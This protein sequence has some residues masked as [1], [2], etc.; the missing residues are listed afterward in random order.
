MG[1]IRQE[2]P[3]VIFKMLERKWIEELYQKGTMR[4]YAPGKWVQYEIDGNRGQGDKYEGVFA[5]DKNGQN[6]EAE[7]RE[8]Y[9]E[10][11][12]VNYDGINKYYQLQET[13]SSPTYCFYSLGDQH[14]EVPKD[15]ETEGQYEIKTV[16]AAD[17]F[18]DFARGMS[19]EEIEKLPK[20]EQPALL[21][22]FGYEN[23]KTFFKKVRQAL[24]HQHGIKDSEVL[25]EQVKYCY[26]RQDRDSYV[27]PRTDPPKEL[28][29]KG[30]EFENQREAR[31]VLD[32]GRHKI[33]DYENDFVEIEIGSMQ[34]YAFIHD[35]YTPNGIAISAEAVF[36]EK[37]NILKRDGYIHKGYE[38]L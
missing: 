37:Q 31:I 35:G 27:S 36:S 30:R 16:I 18:Q 15:I 14:F 20:E 29:E 38:G 5:I 23:I 21:I 33:S 4:F 7:Y 17:Y 12:I 25:I 24:K 2:R 9:G 13:L 28:F 32:T 10:Q 19:Q 26:S 3:H 34:Q 1:Y 11:L 8:K 22:I 6:R